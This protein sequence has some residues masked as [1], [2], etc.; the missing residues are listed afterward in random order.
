[1]VF[2]VRSAARVRITDVDLMKRLGLIVAVSIFYLIVR[3]VIAPP[4]VETETS[5]D[6]LKAEQCKY[7]WW[8]YAANIGKNNSIISSLFLVL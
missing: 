7:D 2:R 1:M 8:D 6:K 4:K 3:S 5:L